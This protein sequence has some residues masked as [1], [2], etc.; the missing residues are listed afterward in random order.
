[1]GQS[2]AQSG[3]KNTSHQKRGEALGGALSDFVDQAIEFSEIDE[4][5]QVEEELGEAAGISVS[6]VQSIK[7]GDIQCPPFER[8]E[9]FADVLSDLLDM[10]RQEILDDLINAGNAD[11][12]E[13]DAETDGRESPNATGYPRPKT[14]SRTS[15]IKESHESRREDQERRSFG[16]VEVRAEDGDERT[17]SGHAA[18]FNERT[19][20][21]TAVGEFEEVIKPGAFDRAL[22]DSDPRYLL[23]HDRNLLMGRVSSG[24]LS[25]EATDRGL[26]YQNTPPETSYAQDAIEVINRGDMRESS[27]GFDVAKDGDNWVE[28]DNDVPLREIREV[29]RLYDV[30]SVTFPA[31]SGTDVGLRAEFRSLQSRLGVNLQELAMLLTH[32]ASGDID[33]ETQK[34]GIK[35][36]QELRQKFMNRRNESTNLDHYER[37]LQLK[38]RAI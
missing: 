19:T 5:Q 9:S 31:Y 38:R 1:M 6:T 12:C 11:G 26:R 2:A 32:T 24:T 13:Y 15:A 22:K 28:R 3:Q 16:M 7:S 8:L 34:R 20:I 36:V 23:N 18:V 35:I 25:L 33:E 14:R 37:E 21:K 29:S 17:I 27:F 10:E 4:A 30:S